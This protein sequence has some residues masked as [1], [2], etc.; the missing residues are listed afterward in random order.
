MIFLFNYIV[1]NI[2]IF[3]PKIVL[4]KFPLTQF[5]IEHHIGNFLLFWFI[6]I[7]SELFLNIISKHYYNISK[8]TRYC[9]FF[10]KSV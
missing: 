5:V 1:S 6:I 10:I 3:N 8:I 7:I 2:F 4:V 9:F